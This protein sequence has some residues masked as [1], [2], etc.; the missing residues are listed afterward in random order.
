MIF[1]GFALSKSSNDPWKTDG[2][3]TLNVLFQNQGK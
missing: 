1:E 2:I 3:N